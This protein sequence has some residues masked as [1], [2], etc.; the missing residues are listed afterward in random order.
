MNI[1]LFYQGNK[2]SVFIESK[3]QL[4]KEMGHA[5]FFLSTTPKGPIHDFLEATFNVPVYSLAKKNSGTAGQLLHYIT[6]VRTFC[7]A[8]QI[9]VV[10][11]HLQLANLSALLAKRIAKIKVV[12]CRH[13]SDYA[14]LIN[15]KN[16]I[17]LDKLVTFLSKK[18]VVV[19]NKAKD[20]M[21]NSEKANASKIVPIPLGY[22]FD[23]YPKPNVEKVTRL[24][25]ETNA[26]LRLIII[27]RMVPTKKHQLAFNL[28]KKLKEN[29]YNVSLIVLDGGVEEEPLRT[30]VKENK[31][32]ENI[33]FYGF[34]NNIIDFLAAADLIIHPSISESSNQ[35][36]KEGTLVGK[37]AIVCSGVGDFDEYLVHDHNAFV[38]SR[39]NMFEEMYNILT[40]VYHDRTELNRLAQNLK[41][42]VEKRFDIKKVVGQYLALA[43]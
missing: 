7:K 31:L 37:T 9:E 1:L 19:S 20:F 38:V 39:E 25:K 3:C 27:S 4:L 32:Q 2:R 29:S 11:S 10:F 40:K 30:F 33:H 26:V 35:I 36:I 6:G 28:I 8:H 43:E 22:N 5:I 42:E 41:E 34:Q 23:L 13:H 18:L 16:D 14:F 12:P 15:N 17:R 21:V 24:K